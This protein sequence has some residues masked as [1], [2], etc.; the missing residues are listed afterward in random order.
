M[1]C[2][3]EWKQ[4]DKAPLSFKTPNKREISGSCG[5]DVLMRGFYE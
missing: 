2:G 4:K 5:L 1:K 3:F